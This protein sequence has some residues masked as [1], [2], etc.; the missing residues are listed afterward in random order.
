VSAG[1]LAH[2]AWDVYHH[3]TGR[4][5]VRSMAEF[6]GVL[7]TLLALVVLGATFSG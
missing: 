1:L 6:C 7:D 4:V 3:R 2:A 5:V